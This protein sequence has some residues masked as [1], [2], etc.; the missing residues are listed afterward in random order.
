MLEDTRYKIQD[1]LDQVEKVIEVKDSR[2]RDLENKAKTIE[3]ENITFKIKVENILGDMK[4]LTKSVVQQPAD[5]MVFQ[6]T[7][8]QNEKEK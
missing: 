3:A 1:R 6:I 5:A 2:I 4:K 7:M 8:L